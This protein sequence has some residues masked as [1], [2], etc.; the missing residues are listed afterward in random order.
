MTREHNG[1]IYTEAKLNE[2]DL[3]NYGTL[4]DLSVPDRNKEDEGR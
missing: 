3:L 1:K 2:L 4:V